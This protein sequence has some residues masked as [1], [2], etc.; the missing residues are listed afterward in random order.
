MGFFSLGCE[1]VTDAPFYLSWVV[2]SVS[3]SIFCG[4]GGGW[5]GNRLCGVKEGKVE[6]R[7]DWL[8]MLTLSMQFIVFSTRKHMCCSTKAMKSDL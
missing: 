3:L 4:V 2:F 7:Q 5:A 6:V 1:H 8:R